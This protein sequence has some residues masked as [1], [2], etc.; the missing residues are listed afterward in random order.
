MPLV[1]LDAPLDFL[2]LGCDL[3]LDDAWLRLTMLISQNRCSSS[4]PKRHKTEILSF[5]QPE[6]NQFR[7]LLTRER[8]IWLLTSSLLTF[9]YQSTKE[10]QTFLWILL[11]LLLC[12]S[13]LLS[14]PTFTPTS[15]CWMLCCLRVD[16]KKEQRCQRPK[17]HV[18][19]YVFRVA[20]PHS[21]HTHKNCSSKWIWFTLAFRATLFLE[22]VKNHHILW[23]SI[24]Q[25][26][27]IL[28]GTSYYYSTMNS[29]HTF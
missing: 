5:R 10:V 15:N 18:H 3:C 2:G 27:W 4:I 24:T 6:V 26:C 1:A 21:L 11:R 22:E 16:A 19:S 7:L 17:N 13:I 20:L 29:K 23:Y 12:N 8:Q 25:A 9:D 14:W 28:E